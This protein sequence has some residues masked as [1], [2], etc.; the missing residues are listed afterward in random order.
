MT[1]ERLAEIERWINAQKYHSGANDDRCESCGG[2]WEGDHTQGRE[3]GPD[4][5]CE[6]VM[7]KDLLT[8]YQAVVRELA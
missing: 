6:V 2:L 4:Y 5:P 1:P 7:L 3:S 8:A